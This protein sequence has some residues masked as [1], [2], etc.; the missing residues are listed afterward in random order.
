MVLLAVVSC[1]PAG[2]PAGEVEVGFSREE[3]I[4]AVGQPDTTQEFT[5]PSEPFFGPQEGL[6]NILAPGTLVEEWAYE[7]ND[8][9]L[10]VWFASESGEP[11][12]D[13]PVV[14]TGVYP[15]GA[16]F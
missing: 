11:R 2:S 8:E 1:S 13:W 5:L 4:E 6:A 14:A 10:Y 12:E 7:L 3:V 15:A 16:V 9:I